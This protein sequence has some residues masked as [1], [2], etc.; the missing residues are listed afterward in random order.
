MIRLMDQYRGRVEIARERLKEVFAHKNKRPAHVMY[1][2][3]YSH[4]GEL[5]ERIDDRYYTDYSVMLAEQIKRIERHFACG[6][7]DCYEP[8]IFPWYGSGVLASAFGINVLF[9][10]K[11]DPAV[12]I[13]AVSED[14]VEL[15]D[16]LQMPDPYKDGLMPRTL[17]AIDY[18]RKNCDIPVGLTDMQGPFTTALQIIGY[19]NFCYWALDYPEKIHQLMNLVSDALIM[20]TKTMKEHM[21]IEPNQS[22]YF[23]SIYIPDGYGGI[24]FSDDD[25]V[26]LSASMYEEF[27]KPYNEKVIAAFGGTGGLHCCG[28]V[29]HQIDNLCAT[30]G[31]T[32]YHNYTTGHIK[33]SGEMKRKLCETG[34]SYIVCDFAPPAETID[35]YFDQLQDAFPDPTGLI[36]E[37]H[38]LPGVVLKR[39]ECVLTQRDVVTDGK[40][41][42]QS[43][44][45]HYV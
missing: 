9:Q 12:E 4:F 22:G 29:I 33:E 16:R 30:D 6:Y 24:N 25:A 11:A 35:E 17:G 42:E 13:I 19:D 40:M 18:F 26:I 28:K 1:D 43:I 15:I 44:L 21:G 14:D 39:G 8:F 45:R 31:L 27:V 3:N 20:W 36:I 5:P 34:K 41:I 2:V 10:P 38:V 32:V 23:Q 37:T 7:D